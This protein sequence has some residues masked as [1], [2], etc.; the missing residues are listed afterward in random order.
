MNRALEA[1]FVP[2]DEQDKFEPITNL[3]EAFEGLF[4]SV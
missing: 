4:E 2:T 1:R 3:Q